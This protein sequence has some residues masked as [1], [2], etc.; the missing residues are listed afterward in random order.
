MRTTY[1]W[2]KP[3][4]SR[5]GLLINIFANQTILHIVCA[6]YNIFAN[7]LLSTTNVCI[8][9][10]FTISLNQFVVVAHRYFTKHSKMRQSHW[11]LLITQAYS[12]LDQKVMDR[13]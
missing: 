5:F 7:S 11:S 13:N 3:I 6:S 4:A 8:C 12:N 10:T 9:D 2:F 1:H